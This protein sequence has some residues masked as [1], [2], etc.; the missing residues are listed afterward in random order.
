MIYFYITKALLKVEGKIQPRLFWS[1]KVEEIE[2]DTTK[3]MHIDIVFGEL[4]IGKFE[5]CYDIW[6]KQQ[7]W[8]QLTKKVEIKHVKIL[9]CK[10]ITMNQV[11]RSRI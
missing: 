3:Q 5:E 11:I 9:Y 7:K 8:I 10:R 6:G 2:N 1:P 4:A